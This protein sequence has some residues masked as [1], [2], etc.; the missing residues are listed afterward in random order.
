MTAAFVNELLIFDAAGLLGAIFYLCSYGALQFGWLDGNSLR[1]SVLNGIAAA[2][3][4][5]S[6]Y[7][8]FNLA[9]A[10]IQI[11]WITVS[12]VGICRQLT[13]TLLAKER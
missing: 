1:Y 4:L 2:L 7:K 11:M 3:V 8:S 10:L 12:V 13:T 5:L 9:S 6:L